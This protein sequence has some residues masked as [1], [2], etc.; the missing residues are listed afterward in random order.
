MVAMIQRA[1]MDGQEQEVVVGSNLVWP[2][3]LTIDYTSQ[4]LYWADAML[5]RIESSNVDGSNRHVLTTFGVH[6]PFS[7]AILGS[8]LYWSDWTPRA[9]MTGTSG[10]Y[11][12]A[13]VLI[14]I[15]GTDP[16]GLQAISIHRQPLGIILYLM[17]YTCRNT[18]LSR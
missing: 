6:H 9:I 11:L 16:M 15:N 17:F 5:D 2:N 7:L 18:F 10:V 13:S 4:S 3:G 12:R 14:T 1:S 8:N